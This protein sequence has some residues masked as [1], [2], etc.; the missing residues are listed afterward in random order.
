MPLTKVSSFGCTKETV[1]RICLTVS[2][3]L[4]LLVDNFQ[5]DW[6]SCNK[7][8][9]YCDFVHPNSIKLSSNSSGKS[10]KTLPF[11][12]FDF[13][14]ST[15]DE[16]FLFN[17]LIR[18]CP[19]VYGAHEY[20]QNR[21]KKLPKQELFKDYGI[22][23]TVYKNF[24]F[25]YYINTSKPLVNQV[26]ENLR[27]QYLDKTIPLDFFT[28]LTEIDTFLV[29][30]IHK[31][32][33]QQGT[34]QPMFYFNGFVFT[35]K[36]VIIV[37][38]ASYLIE[39][40]LREQNYMI[41]P[42]VKNPAPS[43]TT[44]KVEALNNERDHISQKSE[45][46]TN[47]ADFRYLNKNLVLY[48]NLFLEL[49]LC[50]RGRAIK[51]HYVLPI[52]NISNL[53]PQ[54]PNIQLMP[55]KLDTQRIV[56]PLKIVIDE[57]L[58]HNY[59]WIEHLGLKHDFDHSIRKVTEDI[60][61]LVAALDHYYH[62]IRF[63]PIT[64]NNPKKYIVSFEISEV[65]VFDN[66]ELY[67]LT[68]DLDTP[69]TSDKIPEDRDYCINHKNFDR[70][71][72]LKEIFCDPLSYIQFY[73]N[74][75]RHH[76]YFPNT[77]SEFQRGRKEPVKEWATL[78]LTYTDFYP[79]HNTQFYSF[80][81]NVREERVGLLNFK[82][83]FKSEDTETLKRFSKASR[84]HERIQMGNIMYSM[85]KVVSR[86][87]MDSPDSN[88]YFCNSKKP[89]SKTSRPSPPTNKSSD[90]RSKRSSA[91]KVNY[92]VLNYETLGVLE[93]VRRAARKNLE[94]FINSIKF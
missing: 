79:I 26:L 30:F 53:P 38:N 54:R 4:I 18:Y 40:A 83:V 56:F 72:E 69:F 29:G 62:M 71:V 12:T 16:N 23:M 65:V 73:I 85:V 47:I 77:N 24:D 42:I 28:T 25:K 74:Y 57:K 43:K 86:L 90:K 34:P 92:N 3:L 37:Q 84:N 64:T 75:K 60:I 19:V 44:M 66:N 45:K 33:E 78:L 93:C 32:N 55:L 80:V 50:Q 36:D 70:Y 6:S 11:T 91:F 15:I 31:Y 52:L 51:N 63:D 35:N 8:S 22:K 49:N 68:D 1:F 10:E 20:Y 39:M 61:I 81:D 87:L 89:E 7:L 46:S 13:R 14:F 76:I 27:Y 58:L 9:A 2:S 41:K 48:K 59:H 94:K 82:S 17:N 88:E 21:V 67:H 5:I